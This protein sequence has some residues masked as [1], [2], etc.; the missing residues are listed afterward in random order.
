MVLLYARNQIY[1]TSDGPLE[2]KYNRLL[3]RSLLAPFLLASCT[4]LLVGQKA[5]RP[6]PGSMFNRL[7]LLAYSWDFPTNLVALI[8]GAAFFAVLLGAR[9]LLRKSPTKRIFLGIFLLSL[10]VS[11]PHTV[12]SP[13]FEA[14]DEPDHF[15]GLIASVPEASILAQSAAELSVRGQLTRIYNQSDAHFKSEDIIRQSTV[16]WLQHMDATKMENRSLTTKDLWSAV[17]S[18]FQ[19]QQANKLLLCLRLFHCL[20][21]CLSIG[22]VSA[23]TTRLEASQEAGLMTGLALLL[24]PALPFFGMHVSNY[25]L[26]T[27]FYILSSLCFPLGLKLCRDNSPWPL[28]ALAFAFGFFGFLPVLASTSALSYL[29][30]PLCWGFAICVC[31]LRISFKTFGLC[32]LSMCLGGAILCLTAL[33]NLYHLPPSIGRWLFRIQLLIVSP[34]IVPLLTALIVAEI[35]A[36]LLL[37]FFASRNIASSREPSNSRLLKSSHYFILMIGLMMVIWPLLFPPAMQPNIELGHDLSQWMYVR[38]SVKKFFLNF[39]TL[40]SDVYLCSMFWAGFGWLEMQVQQSFMMLP[41]VLVPLSLIFG[42]YRRIGAWKLSTGYDGVLLIGSFLGATIAIT[43]MALELF[44]NV[45]LHGR[46]LIGV[47]VTLIVSSVIYL[48]SGRQTLFRKPLSFY[49]LWAVCLMK[50]FTL[51][52]LLTRYF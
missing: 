47:E 41:K 21:F 28:L 50:G 15:R 18:V 11:L 34:P 4:V 29:I 17:R 44:P 51:K 45:N 25:G 46:Y 36:C 23:L 48:T 9:E 2:S 39:S 49:G 43:I 10:G 7:D 5:L 31:K 26:L 3:V 37:V 38:S 19:F 1:T 6:L 13:P 22:L 20:I 12:V 24:V 32:L 8:L 33:P 35:F 16:P 52:F 14:P 30:F 27:S 42:A 40:Y